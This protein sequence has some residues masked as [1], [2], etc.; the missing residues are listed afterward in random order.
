[1]KFYKINFIFCTAYNF[2]HLDKAYYILY[3]NINH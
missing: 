2:S 1:M 3:T